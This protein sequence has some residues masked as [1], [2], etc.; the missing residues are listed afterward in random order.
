MSTCMYTYVGVKPLAC[1]NVFHN[2]QSVHKTP[3]VM[4]TA[5]LHTLMHTTSLPACQPIHQSINL[6]GDSPAYRVPGHSP[7]S[8]GRTVRGAVF[9]SAGTDGHTGQRSPIHAETHKTENV[10]LL[11]PH[12]HCEYRSSY[13]IYIY[14]YIHVCTRSS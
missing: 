1:E 3:L 13:Y 12:V 14:I 5:I 2:T 6:L 9:H 7:Y 4:H 11:N 8:C 10:K